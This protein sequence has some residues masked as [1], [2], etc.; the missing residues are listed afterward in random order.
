[1]KAVSREM[2]AVN[3]LPPHNNIVKLICVEEEVRL[4]S[5]VTTRRVEYMYERNSFLE[6]GISSIHCS[7]L[8]DYNVGTSPLW[9]PF[10]IIRI[11][12]LQ[13]ITVLVTVCTLPTEKYS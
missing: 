11:Y 5:G 6:T 1:M 4:H 13:L 2:D 8:T 12:T 3:R 7:R 10:L 9:P